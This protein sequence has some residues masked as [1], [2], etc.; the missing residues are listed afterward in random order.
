MLVRSRDHARSL[1]VCLRA[2][3]LARVH[4]SLATCFLL[5]ACSTRLNYVVG[6]VADDECATCQQQKP[7]VYMCSRLM[8]LLGWSCFRGCVT[9]ITVASSR[10]VGNRE[11]R[12]RYLKRRPMGRF[13]E[14]HESDF[15]ARREF[16]LREFGT[17]CLKL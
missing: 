11:A 8:G 3:R 2:C 7:H 17:C 6:G 16:W 10:S 1:P 14:F 9:V 12:R 13:R 15:D 5:L 4:A